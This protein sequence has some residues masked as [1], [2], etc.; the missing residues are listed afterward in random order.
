MGKIISS[1]EVALPTPAVFM[2]PVLSH[3]KGAELYD[4]RRNSHYVLLEAP[5]IA[6]ADPNTLRGQNITLSPTV[7][8]AVL[9][10]QEPP[11]HPLP[12]NLAA[13]L[14]EAG[15]LNLGTLISTNAASF[16]NIVSTLATLSAELAKASATLTGDAQRQVL[17]AATD[18]NKQVGGLVESGLSQASQLAQSSPST[19][20]TP[21]APQQTPPSAAPAP[22]ATQQVKSKVVHEQERI[23]KSSATPIQ[24]AERKAA[25]GAPTREPASL[26]YRFKLTFFDE[27]GS[28][29]PEG[30]FTATFVFASPNSPGTTDIVDL[31]GARPIPFNLLGGFTT[32][33]QITLETGRL[34]TFAFNT[35]VNGINLPGTADF[36][37]PANPDVLQHVRLGF[38]TEKVTTT[39][40]ITKLKERSLTTKFGLAGQLLF[41]ALLNG[42]AK[43]PLFK[44]FEIEAGGGSKRALDLKAQFERVSGETNTD[45]DTSTTT[46]EYEMHLPTGWVITVNPL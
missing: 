21:A 26:N 22:P 29:F 10:Q 31:N 40:V 8:G 1:D 30:S 19:Q 44:V 32:T 36:R 37:L 27:F 23:D 46:R 33:E 3:S 38:T 17:Q 42:T 45:T 24:K 20:P 12:G 39:N 14:S 16:Q 9:Q 13:A 2:E 35:D 28:L 15:R 43:F 7:P 25:I 41:E 11:Q 18:V 6:A 34:F 5:G 4:M